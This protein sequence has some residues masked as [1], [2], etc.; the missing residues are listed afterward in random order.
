MERLQGKEIIDLTKE[1]PLLQYKELREE[2]VENIIVAFRKPRKAALRRTKTRIRV[3]VLDF[4]EYGVDA[5][6][7]LFDN[8]SIY[9]TSTGVEIGLLFKLQ[10]KVKQVRKVNLKFKPDFK[11][12]IDNSFLDISHKKLA[13][14]IRI[15]RN[16]YIHY[17]NILAYYAKIQLKDIPELIEQGVMSPEVYNLIR[18]DQ[19]NTPIRI[20]HLETNEEIMPFINKRVK[21]HTN[22]MGSP[23]SRMIAFKKR[24]NNTEQLNIQ[25]LLTVFGQ[26]AFDSLTCIKW[27]LE[28]LKELYII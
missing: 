6:R 10:N 15:M 2:D 12:L 23:I 24:N 8:A 16:C 3:Y 7:Y 11:W 22:C 27:S 9:Y 14:D 1:H 13:H 28:V 26:Q 5:Y 20:E 25:E 17:Q 21:E 4:F 18:S 19:D